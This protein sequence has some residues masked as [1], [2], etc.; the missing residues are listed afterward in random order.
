MPS[1]KYPRLLSDQRPDD[2][3]LVRIVGARS[4]Q[5]GSVVMRR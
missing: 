3:K 1:I 5:G 2:A 4:E